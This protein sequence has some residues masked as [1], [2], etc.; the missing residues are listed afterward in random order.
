MFYKF[1]Y[2]LLMSS[3]KSVHR[4]KI[5]K[6]LYFAPTLS[7]A[8][9]SL[10][11]KKSLPLTTRILNEL[12]EA[13][14]V[15]EIGPAPSTGGR[16]PIMYSLKQDVCYIVSVAMDQFVTRIA[17]MDMSNSFVTEVEEIELPLLGNAQAL[18]VLS[19]SIEKVIKNSGITKQ[20]KEGFK[21]REKYFTS[22]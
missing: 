19:N 21:Y 20:T 9:L 7:C 8:S 5:I 11:I 4:R 22:I 16:R 14:F 18:S 1:E 10:A 15:T 17:I 6:Q 12:I 3:K 13:G 2:Y